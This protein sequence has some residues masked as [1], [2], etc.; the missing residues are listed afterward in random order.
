MSL[1]MTQAECEAFLAEPHVGVISVA[2][3]HRGP[4]SVPVW[5]AYTPGGQVDVWTGRDSAKVKLARRAGCFTLCVQTEQQPYKYVSVEGPVTGIDAIDFERELVPL[6]ARYVG[7]ERA[8]EF[9]AD[10][11]GEEEAADAVMLRMRP[12]SWY[13]EDHATAE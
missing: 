6:A 10:Y 2:R 13:S 3:P 9:L 7:S 8:R 11:G 1:A 4:L 5:Y 12:Q